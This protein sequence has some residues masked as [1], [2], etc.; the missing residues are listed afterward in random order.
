M[1][2][3]RKIDIEKEIDMSVVKCSLG[4]APKPKGELP[5]LRLGNPFGELILVNEQKRVV[6]TGVRFNVPVLVFEFDGTLRQNVKLSNNGTLVPPGQEVV[7][8]LECVVPVMADAFSAFFERG[9]SL[10][11]VV[12]LTSDGVVLE[13]TP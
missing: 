12:P 7:A 5:L 3:S 4:D 8:H 13:F 1:G 11:Q 2:S 9:D 10:L 6:G